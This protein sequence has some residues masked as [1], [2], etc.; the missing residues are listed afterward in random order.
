MAVLDYLNKAVAAIQPYE[1]GRPIE[2]VAR[3][4]GLD[5]ASIIKLASNESALGPSPKAVAAMQ[6]ELANTHV[7][8]DGGAWLLRNR[9]AE[10]YGLERDQVIVGN[11]SNEILEFVGHCFLHSGNSAVFSR[12]A[13]VVYKL[14]SVLFGTRQIEVPMADGL[15][16]D[17]DAMLAAIDG[18]TRVVFLCNP[19][20]PTGTM[21]EPAAI[22][23]FV[24]AVPED[25]LVVIDEAYAEIALAPMPDSLGLLARHPNV[26]ISRTF[27]KAYGLAGLRLGYALGAPELIRALQQARQPFNTNLLAQVAGTAALDDQAFVDEQKTLYQAGKAQLEAG[28]EALGLAYIP[29]FA[30]F[31]LIEVRDGA[32][33]TNA[34]QAQGV[35]VRPMGGYGLPSYLRVTFGTKEQNSRF[36]DTLATLLQQA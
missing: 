4:L 24:A 34:L 15:V 11:G 12:H 6:A 33:M 20:N 3:Q 2:E 1:P 31:M 25:V 13:F 28:C 21:V 32:A 30:N 19:N 27:S 22:E 26:L 14:V 23:A 36:L 10:H 9:I 18:D 35:I 29:G 16:H 17:L 7:Y 5:P 8:P